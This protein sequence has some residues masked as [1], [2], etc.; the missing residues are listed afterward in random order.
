LQIGCEA[1][2]KVFAKIYISIAIFLSFLLLAKSEG[3]I[4]NTTSLK[5]ERDQK[6]E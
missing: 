4:K 1:G 6:L 3:K 2:W 5:N